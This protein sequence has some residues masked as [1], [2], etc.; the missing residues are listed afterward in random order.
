[1]D[2]AV[3]PGWD[4]SKHPRFVA[5]ITGGGLADIVGFGEDGVWTALGNGDGSFQPARV[6]LPAFTINTGGWRV[7]KHPRFL[8]DLTGKG[9][10]DIVGFGDDGVW[11]ALSNGDGTFQPPKFVIA[12]L[13]FNSAW[14]VERHPH[15]AADLTGE[16]RA[17][18]IGFGDAG[19]WTA[20]GN[21]DGTSQPPNFVIADLGF[22]GGGWRV[23]KHPR[24]VARLTANTRSDI[25][26]FGDAGVWTAL[27]K[28]TARSS[29]RRL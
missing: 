8:A 23:E 9:R 4:V 10:A 25:V 6:V 16:G 12:D 24:F 21:G 11:T 13:G 14:R 26:G 7:E 27:S 19:V 17:D 29:R 2:I 3:G 22:T 18:L 15:F 5:D 20:V 28:G 1:M